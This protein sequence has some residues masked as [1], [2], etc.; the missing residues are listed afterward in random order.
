MDTENKEL[1][2]HKFEEF[3]PSTETYIIK[4]NISDVNID[5]MF[6]I[7]NVTEYI[8]I[9]KKRGRR[10]MNEVKDDPNKNVSNGSIISLKSQERRKG[11]ILDKKKNTER[12]TYFRNAISISIKVD[13]KI[14]NAKFSKNGTVQI[15]GCKELKHAYY[16]I[17]Y[18][19]R[20][21]KDYVNIY[22]LKDDV[23]SAI[24][25]PAMRNISFDLG[26][27]CVDRHEIYKIMNELKDKNI[28]TI[29]NPNAKYT[30][31]TITHDIGD[32]SELDLDRIYV[33]NKLKS[34]DSIEKYVESIKW[35]V[36][37]YKDYLKLLTEKEQINK[38][39]KVRKLSF[40]IFQTGKV[41]IS[42]LNEE[43]SKP[44]YYKLMEILQ[45]EKDNIIEYFDTDVE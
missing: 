45:K 34:T 16:T 40:V 39:K 5:K 17:L 22:T 15:T 4:T 24:F 31:L 25:I 29:Y 30:A 43:Y 6:D 18:I 20:Y 21:I 41:T 9:Q 7:I 19:W 28:S 8:V 26:I 2:I 33:P 35:D 13:G 23:F 12:N 3:K 14:V 27:G 32:I 42:S 44:I 1:I 10:K 38:K 36:I 37:K 11:A